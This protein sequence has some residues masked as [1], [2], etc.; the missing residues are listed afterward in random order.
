MSLKL[1]AFMVTPVMTPPTPLIETTG[2]PE[3]EARAMA[4][5]AASLSASKALAAASEALFVAERAFAVQVAT[6]V[7]IESALFAAD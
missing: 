5:A 4:T 6:E 1:L 7:V 3:I 2:P